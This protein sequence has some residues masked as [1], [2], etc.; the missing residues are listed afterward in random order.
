[1]SSYIVMNETLLKKVKEAT[2]ASYKN[3][4]YKIALK[5]PKYKK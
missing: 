2:Y 3:Y 4:I 5:T 1:M